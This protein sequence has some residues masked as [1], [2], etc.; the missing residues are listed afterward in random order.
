MQK[1]LRFFCIFYN[2]IPADEINRPS[3]LGYKNGYMI[4][5]RDIFLSVLF[6]CNKLY[7]YIH[8]E[9]IDVAEVFERE[10]KIAE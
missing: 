9:V 6:P 8:P 2:G 1:S 3:L 5:G 10:I 7:I 4:F